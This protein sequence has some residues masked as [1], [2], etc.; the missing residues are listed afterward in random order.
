MS[1][2]FC[3]EVLTQVDDLSAK[4]T[5]EL[6]LVMDTGDESLSPRVLRPGE[7]RERPRRTFRERCEA[8]GIEM[9]DAESSEEEDIA[10]EQ[11]IIRPEPPMVDLTIEENGIVVPEDEEV[12]P[13]VAEKPKKPWRLECQNF[14]F[15]Y[16]Q[17]PVTKERA[18]EFFRKLFANKFKWC[19]VGREKHQDGNYHLHAV[20]A[21][22][23][24]TNFKNERFGD[25]DGYH[26]SY[27]AVK[28]WA[29]AIG[30][31][32]KD[33]DYMVYPEGVDA[34]AICTAAGRS[35]M[36]DNVMRMLA[37]GASLRTIRDTYPGYYLQ[38][39]ERI[40]RA[41]AE[42]AAE[43]AVGIALG[44]DALKKQLEGALA[45]GLG[46]NQMDH[47]GATKVLLWI[48]QNF[49]PGVVRLPRQK[50][51]YLFG[52]PGIG[53]SRLKDRMERYFDLYEIP[54]DIDFYCGYQEGLFQGMYLDEFCGGKRVQWLNKV[55][56][57]S[58]VTLNQKNGRVMKVTNHPIM[59][60]AN[61]PLDYYY[62]N[63]SQP[64]ARGRVIFDALVDRLEIVEVTAADMDFIDRAF[65]WKGASEVVEI[66]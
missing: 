25:I 57:G 6:G 7:E 48:K 61:E 29:R 12:V 20:V 49:F 60:I 53:K 51:L 19:I 63:I 62:P 15:T 45:T 47:L 35:S 11:V 56:D 46:W 50:Q 4:G 58:R 8:A 55:L 34:D 30:Y 9:L 24:P 26:G 52:P 2:L 28:I 5:D 14:F 23:S 42:Y 18:V 41:H 64:G 43:R 16:S 65:L 10:I 39:G 27:S 33:G 32:K 37:E 44:A 3:S 59:L 1:N 54:N 21:C 38:Q 66:E 22:S 31:C 36:S 13:V 17:C 40:R